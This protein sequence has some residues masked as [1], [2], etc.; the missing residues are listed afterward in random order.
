MRR[1]LSDRRGGIAVMAAVAGGLFCALAALTVDIGSLALHAR[2]LQ[3]AADL[4]ALSGARDLDHAEA[5]ARA[6]AQANAGTGVAATVLKGRYVSDRTLAPAQRF[7]TDA[8]EPNAVRVTLTSQAPLYFGRWILGKNTLEITRSGTAATPGEPRALFSIG[9]R[10]A[11]LDGGVAN[12]LL[13][14]LTGSSVSLSVMDYN[15]LAAAKVNLLAFTDALAADIG[16]QAGDYDA[17]LAHE[18]DAGQA[19]RVLG[20]LAGGQSSSAL[21]RLGAAAVGTRLKVGDLIGAEADAAHGLAQGLDASVSA[22][23]LAMAMLEIGGGDRQIALTTAAQTGIADLHIRLAIGERP[24][25]SPWITVTSKGQPIVRTAQTRLY[26]RA[27]T[28]QKLSGLAQVNLPILIELASSEARLDTMT[29]KPSRT[30]TLGVRPGLARADIGVVDETK[31]DD[32]KQTLTPAPATLMSVA[33]LVSLTGRATV[34]AADQGFKPLAFSDAEI[35]AQTMKTVHATGLVNGVVVSL[36]QKLDVTVNI[37]GLPLGLGGLVSALGT[38]LA[39]LGPVLDAVINPI[40]DALGLRFGEA[41]V[42]VLGA[43][44]PDGAGRPVLV[45]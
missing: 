6:T 15:A 14:G 31:L 22:M 5:A 8:P 10:L 11:A 21:S 13:S 34:E 35:T 7:T 29:C 40:L 18:V 33:G 25:H 2:Q 42:T 12:Q 23:D 24:N 43:V 20:A 16:I 9:S 19:L 4:A 44:C 39:P 38:L 36:L 27:R 32:F 45:G 37:V 30:V 3:G 1:L 41:D 17:L 26:V 28:S